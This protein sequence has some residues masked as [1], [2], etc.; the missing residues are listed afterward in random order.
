[1]QNIAVGARISPLELPLG[2]Q[3]LQGA[4]IIVKTIVVPWSNRYSYTI[5]CL[6]KTSRSC[7][8]YL[9]L[10]IQA[11]VRPTTPHEL[12]TGAAN[13]ESWPLQIETD[14]RGGLLED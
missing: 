10:Q 13:F 2:L 11:P 6:K 1:M 3:V 9:G 5:I 12:M 4:S 8:N 14:S 7:S